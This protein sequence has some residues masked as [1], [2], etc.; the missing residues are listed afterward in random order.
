MSI[1]AKRP[2]NG[3][4]L[5]PLSYQGMW[6]R[7]ISTKNYQPFIVLWVT[8]FWLISRLCSFFWICT[9]MERMMCGGLTGR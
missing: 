8:W 2:H 3:R 9:V 6:K 5:V 4:T 1:S 7:G